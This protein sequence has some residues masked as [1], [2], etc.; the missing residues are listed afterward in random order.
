VGG[1]GRGGHKDEGTLVVLVAQWG[2]R[3]QVEARGHWLEPW[4]GE[5]WL[6]NERVRRARIHQ[7]EQYCVPAHSTLGA[8]R[9]Y[10]LSEGG[11]TMEALQGAGVG[12]GA[13][14]VVEGVRVGGKRGNW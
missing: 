11:G 8:Q 9:E 14:G 1:G 2:G 12:A 7:E 13:R 5:E 6:V 3:K 10:N 4:G